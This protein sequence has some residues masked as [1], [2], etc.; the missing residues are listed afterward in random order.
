[1]R[2][3]NWNTIYD[4]FKALNDNSIRYVVLRN[5]EAM[6]KEDFFVDGH[7]D[8]DILCE[9]VSAFTEVSKVFVR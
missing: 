8:I 7:E 1:M 2:I 9:D 3:H 4:F 6:D 5:F